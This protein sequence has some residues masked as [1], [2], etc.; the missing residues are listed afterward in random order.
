[1]N[2]LVIASVLCW[3]PWSLTWASEVDLSAIPRTIDESP[4]IQHDAPGYCLLVFGERAQT[5]AWLVVDGQSVYIDRN[6]NG[7]L[8][9]AGERIAL[10]PGFI[11]LGEVQ[12]SETGVVQAKLGLSIGAGAKPGSSFRLSSSLDQTAGYGVYGA[13][14]FGDSPQ[15]APILHFNGPMTFARYGPLSFLPRETDGVSYRKTYLRLRAGSPGVGENSF[16]GYDFCAL[17]Y[18]CGEYPSIAAEVS[19]P[20]LDPGDMP[21]RLTQALEVKG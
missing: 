2:R 21:I 12:D 13:P 7:D 9:E 11:D 20:S 10:T 8:T 5:R 15:S 3:C 6:A 17:R 16:V 4:D 14:T 18:K 1:M 19:F